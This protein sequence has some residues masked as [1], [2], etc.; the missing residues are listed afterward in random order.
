M[1]RNLPTRHRISLLA[2][3]LLA[4]ACPLRVNAWGLSTELNESWAQARIVFPALH[5]KKILF[6]IKNEDPSRF[7]SDSIALQVESAL[8]LWLEPVAALGIT[9]IEVARVDCAAAN[10]NLMVQLGQETQYTGLGSYQLSSWNETHY[11]SLVKFDSGFVSDYG[12]KKT[13][14]TDFRKFTRNLAGESAQIQHISFAAPQTV[15]GFSQAQ[16]LDSN[17]VF[18]STYPSLIHE[19]G[20]SFGLCDTYEATEKDQCDPAFSSATHPSSVM[21][22]SNFFYLTPD[23]V[24]AIQR[25]FQRFR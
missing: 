2:L 15:F 1:D 19:L 13:Q 7:D 3:A 4:F 22:E 11:Y 9:G 6:C 16:S 23:D 21:K 17:E 12:G 20:H 14:I 24:T 18:W 8:R 10:F 5:Q 25:L